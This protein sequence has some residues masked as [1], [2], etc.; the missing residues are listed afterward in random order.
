MRCIICFRVWLLERKFEELLFSLPVNIF[1][2][3][4]SPGEPVSSTF[5]REGQDRFRDSD[6]LAGLLYKSQLFFLQNSVLSFALSPKSLKSRRC[7]FPIFAR[8]L[9]FAFNP[10]KLLPLNL[11]SNVRLNICFLES[12]VTLTHSLNQ[13]SQSCCH[14]VHVDYRNDPNI[15]ET[16]RVTACRNL[17]NSFN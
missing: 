12:S 11:I 2:S 1:K 13:P 3:D 16:C 17:W 6:L 8:F 14:T 15:P 4:F 9:S 5:M 10:L 7:S